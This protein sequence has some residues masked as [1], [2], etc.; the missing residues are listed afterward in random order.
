[1]THRINIFCCLNVPTSP[2]DNFLCNADPVK[3]TFANLKKN[4]TFTGREQQNFK[5]GRW[6]RK[7]SAV[8]FESFISFIR[9]AS[10]VG[11]EKLHQL[12]SKSFIG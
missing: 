6:T 10:S 8:E 7:A 3:L 9:K 4:T 1:M 11:F 12:D 2:A 5:H